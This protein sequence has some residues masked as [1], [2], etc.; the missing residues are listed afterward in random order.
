[1]DSTQARAE[2]VRSGYLNSKAMITGLALLTVG[3]VIGAWGMGISGTAMMR[4]FRRWLT[5]QQQPISAIAGHK[6]VPA[7]PAPT[8]SGGRK[9]MATQAAR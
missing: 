6:T 3:G 5:A 1:M 2:C 4:R 8:V 9:E 7:K